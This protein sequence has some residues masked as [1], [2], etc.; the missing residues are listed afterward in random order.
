MVLGP[1]VGEKMSDQ[2]I[3]I[4]VIDDDPELTLTLGATLEAEG[5]DVLVAN[6][7]EHGLELAYTRRPHLVLLDVAMPGMD[8]YEVCRELQFGYT[9]DIPVV[10]LTARTGLADMMEAN[11]SGASAFIT[12]PFR[13][14][15]LLETVR[16]VLRDASA[17]YD[18]ITG[19]PTLAHVQ[20]EV[21]RTM[22]DHS[23]LGILYVTV[24]NVHVIEQTQGFEVV[25]EMFRAIG[26]RL[27]EARGRLIRNEDFVSISSLGNA[28]LVILSPARDQAFVGVDDLDAVRVRLKEDLLG[29]IEEDLEMAL[30][31][32]AELRVGCARL[33]QSPKVRFKRALMGAIDDATRGIERE[34]DEV[35]H[36]LS[37]EFGRVVDA[38][39]ISCVYQP[40]VSLG[41]YVVRG[42]ELLA[43]GPM[44]SELH[45]PDALFE[46]A[47]A[48]SRVPELDRICR[49]MAAR[50]AATL[51]PHCLRFINA[52]PIN[53]FFHPHSDV[54]VREFVE[55]T[56]VALRAQTVVEITENAVIDDFAHMREVVRRLRQS[57][58]RIAIDDAGAGY[59]GLQTMVEIEPDF[60][61][62]DMSLT[63]GIET[64]IVKQKLVGTL[65]DFCRQAFITLVAEGIETHAQLDAL[66]AL[67]IDYGQ[68][69]LFAH[70]GPP[71]PEITTC[72][73]VEDRARASEAAPSLLPGADAA[74]GHH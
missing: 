3:S 67:G 53:L 58:F 66:M 15:H 22:Q 41:D 40:I 54:F 61:K 33:T 37:R 20:V 2:R 24:D 44:E 68:G 43:R 10:F 18:E 19:L 72:P 59:A 25:D 56:P 48:E 42:Y 57:G 9:K 69:F 51:P 12:K 6:S 4:L 46:V 11:R 28:F 14:Q 32:R 49:M 31:A 8:G 50:A 36:R 29:D 47:R 55:A 35:R 21:Q 13:T 62:L 71:H 52:E 34:R 23:Q 70:P 45:Q 65:R 39:D 7:G 30:L 73:P 17:Y 64:S 5:Y 26:R 27:H 63:R 38:E 1:P 74:A 60:I 16:D